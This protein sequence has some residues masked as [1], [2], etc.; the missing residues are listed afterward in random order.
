MGGA[1][2]LQ[3]LE[4]RKGLGIRT[5]S[6]GGT[7]I[8]PPARGCCNLNDKNVLQ[9]RDA[10]HRLCLVGDNSDAEL[11]LIAATPTPDGTIGRKQHGIAV[12]STD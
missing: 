11:A 10:L 5:N 3:A 9:C 8:R 1:E 7:G 2:A 12:P 4:D 6:G